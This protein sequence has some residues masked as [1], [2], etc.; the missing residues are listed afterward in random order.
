MQDD[1][2]NKINFFPKMD[3]M[4]GLKSLTIVA[5]IGV[6]PS[7]SLPSIK[8]GSQTYKQEPFEINGISFVKTSLDPMSTTRD[9]VS[10]LLRSEWYQRG[11]SFKKKIF[12]KSVDIYFIAPLITTNF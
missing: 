3:L 12:L 7:A 2:V 11:W 10:F 5:A 6:D 1:E 8:L 4:F 9:N